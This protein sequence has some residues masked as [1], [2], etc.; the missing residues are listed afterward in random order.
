MPK[1]N[2]SRQ[3]NRI[4]M[5]ADADKQTAH[6][7]QIEQYSQSLKGRQKAIDRFLKN[8]VYKLEE[9][10]ESSHLYNNSFEQP[11]DHIE[12]MNTIDGLKAGSLELQGHIKTVK[13]ELNKISQN[14]PREELIKQ[15]IRIIKNSH[16]KYLSQKYIKMLENE[17]KLLKDEK[18]RIYLIKDRININIED[19]WNKNL[20]K[21]S[22]LFE[23]YGVYTDDIKLELP[24]RVKILSISDYYDAINSTPSPSIRMHAARKIDAD[25]KNF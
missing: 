7:E 8:K 13:D 4:R 16:L 20:E 9:K 11:E 23:E 10:S 21:L 24:S 1:H 14:L 6:S 3:P 2:K 18:R 22:N 17:E 15:Q 19:I 25:T 12:S 5:E